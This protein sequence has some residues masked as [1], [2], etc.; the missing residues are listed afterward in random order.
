MRAI[1]QVRMHVS[2]AQCMHARK[3]ACMRFRKVHASLQAAKAACMQWCVGQACIV[4]MQ[5]VKHVCM[6]A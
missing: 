3:L 2:T 6:Q 1:L 4:C 5:G